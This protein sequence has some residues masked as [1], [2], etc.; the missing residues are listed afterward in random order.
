MFNKNFNSDLI[1]AQQYNFNKYTSGI[2]LQG[3][4]YDYDSVM[5]YHPTSFSINGQAT[6]TPKVDGVS[7]GNKN[8]LSDID[9]AAIRKYYK[10]A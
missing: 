4:P 1:L 3:F 10:C 8:K 9:V 7:I 2:D 6:I 5:H